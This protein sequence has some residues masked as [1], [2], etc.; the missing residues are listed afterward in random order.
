MLDVD[1]L[2]GLYF[3]GWVVAA[4]GLYV[5]GKRYADSASPAKHP[6]A[7]SVLGGAVWPV[8]LIGFFE[9]NGVMACSKLQDKH[10]LRAGISA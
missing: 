3:A 8:L 4:L 6:V 7:V 10:G 2:L 1:I 5:S 9:F